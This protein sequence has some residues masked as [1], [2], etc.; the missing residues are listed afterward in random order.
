LEEDD[1]RREDEAGEDL[2]ADD[3]QLQREMGDEDDG[4][5]GEDADRVDGVEAGSFRGFF[6][7]GVLPA[8]DFSVGPGAGEGDG[9]GAEHGGVDHEQEDCVVDE[10]AAAVGQDGGDGGGELCGV[11]EGDVVVVGEGSG[12]HHGSG[13]ED[14]EDG[15]DES[16]EARP[17]EVGEAE[18]LFGYAALLEEEL[19]RSDGSADDGDDEEDEIAGA[20]GFVPEGRERGD[21]GAGEGLVPVWMEQGGGDEPGDVDEAEDDDDALPAAV[22][23]GGDEGDERDG[24]DG[25][26]DDGSDAEAGHGEGDGGELG[27]E[28]EEVDGE[29]IEEGEAAP[30]FA[31]ALVDHGGVAFA[32]GDAEARDHLLHE[33]ADGK[34]EDEDP[35]EVES[36]LA[37]GLHVGGDGAGVVVG[38][39]DDETGAEDDEEAED[40]AEPGTADEGLVGGLEL[41]LELGLEGGHGRGPPS[42]LALGTMVRSQ[43]LVSGVPGRPVVRQTRMSVGRRRAKV[44]VILRDMGSP[45][46][47]REACEWRRRGRRAWH[48]VFPVAVALGGHCANGRV[49]PSDDAKEGDYRTPRTQRR[50]GVRGLGGSVVD[51]F[52]MRCSSER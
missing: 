12:E 17:L 8:G 47:M 44:V 29:E 51:A 14:G 26:R 25:Y 24:G 43:V 48:V 27:D 6:V 4:C 20:A 49:T 50:K 9:G 10:D 41:R 18:A 5:G 1:G 37:A 39:H 46:C 40:G 35:E 22:A 11:G 52:V 31:E 19:P 7:E 28:G 21:E 32:G 15:A 30:G 33:V 16:V 2:D 45:G 42:V 34:E 3:D 13:Y 36:V 23:A 38:F